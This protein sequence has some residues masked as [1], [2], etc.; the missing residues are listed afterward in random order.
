MNNSKLQMRVM[1]LC[2][3]WLFGV[4]TFAQMPGKNLIPNSGFESYKGR[5]PKGI[6]TSAKPW[7]NVGT[8]DFFY[9]T[10]VK[11]TSVYKG[12]HSGK[13]YVGMRFQKKY[14]EYAYV[15]LLEPLKKGR[16]YYFTMYVRLLDV[17]TVSIKQLGVYFSASPF[18]M[19][20]IFNA[21]GL[22]DTTYKGGLN[23][24]FGWMPITGKYVA[25]GGEKYIIIGN[26]TTNTKEDF[27]KKNKWDIFELKEAFYYLDDVS[28]I[29]T[30]YVPPVK[31]KDSVKKDTVMIHKLVEVKTLYFENS[32]YKLQKNSIIIIEQIMALC[33]GNPS[34]EIEIKGYADNQGGEPLNI[35][36]SKE[37][38]RSVYD[39]LKNKGIANPMKFDGYGSVNPIVPN[40]TPENRA[41]N[42]RV[43]IYLIK[44]F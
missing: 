38:A 21:D 31:V 2:V 19:G 33:K 37:R 29:D 27:V 1:L 34:M 30:S 9:K 32:S 11:D 35:Q 6:V 43:E 14:K 8:V 17:S 5:N 44:K 39:Y 26:F 36:L 15:K 13:C 16:E 7:Q 25:H 12:P 18:K 42:R 3:L 40:D 4:T 41:K 20:M 28:L 10:D 24:G 23:G 22:I